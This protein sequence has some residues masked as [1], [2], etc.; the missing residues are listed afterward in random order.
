MYLVQSTIE[1]ERFSAR[2]TSDS[3][4]PIK[5]LTELVVLYNGGKA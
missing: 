2:Q 3:D 4:H 5:H 1:K